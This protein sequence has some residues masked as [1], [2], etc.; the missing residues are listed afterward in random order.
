MNFG[1]V[2]SALRENNSF[3]KPPFYAFINFAHR[4]IP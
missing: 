1:T 3:L 2:L 4:L